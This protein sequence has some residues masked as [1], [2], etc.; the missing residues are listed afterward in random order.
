VGV[1]DRLTFVHEDRYPALPGQ[2]LDLGPVALA[3]L[4]LHLVEL[5]AGAA[6]PASDLA[7]AA[8]QVRRRLAAVQRGHP[9]KSIGELNFT[10]EVYWPRS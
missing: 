7:A 2:L 5:D 3:E 9:P 8:N 4:D 10:I 1:V 6:Q